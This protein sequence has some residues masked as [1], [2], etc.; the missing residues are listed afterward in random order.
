MVLMGTTM[1]CREVCQGH[2]R[3]AALIVFSSLSGSADEW[4]FEIVIH[5]FR[6][7]HRL[8]STCSGPPCACKICIICEIC[9]QPR[10]DWLNDLVRGVEGDARQVGLLEG[11]YP[12]S[13][14]D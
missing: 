11:D 3:C 13:A 9:G 5:R 6:R 14:T 8:R 12:R 10:S 2:R 4:D 1:D 7:L